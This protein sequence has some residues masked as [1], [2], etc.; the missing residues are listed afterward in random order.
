MIDTKSITW[1]GFKLVVADKDFRPTDKEILDEIHN[2]KN[3]ED[4]FNN[5]YDELIKRV[6][7][8]SLSKYQKYLPDILRKKMSADYAYDVEKTKEFIKNVS[9]EILKIY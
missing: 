6:P 9:V 3:D 7:D 2:M 8:I 1:S 4:Y 5:I